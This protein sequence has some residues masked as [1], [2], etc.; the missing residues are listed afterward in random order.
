MLRVEILR[1]SKIFIEPPIP[2]V[3]NF[4]VGLVDFDD[5]KLSVWLTVIWFISLHRNMEGVRDLRVWLGACTKYHFRS[6]KHRLSIT[7]KPLLPIKIVVSPILL[8]IRSLSRAKR[9][10]SISLLTHLWPP[11][12][13]VVVAPMVVQHVQVNGVPQNFP[14]E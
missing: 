5:L 11:V 10:R 3:K 8:V 13:L 12:F 2:W 4:L 7:S 1:N 14:T 6:W 9:T